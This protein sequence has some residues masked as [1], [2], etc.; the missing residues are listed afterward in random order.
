MIAIAQ[1]LDSCATGAA[2]CES[3]DLVATA[4]VIVAAWGLM[5]LLMLVRQR[6]H[7]RD[8]P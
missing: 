6:L 7:R 5:G 1:G 4:L 3:A 2:Q 8:R